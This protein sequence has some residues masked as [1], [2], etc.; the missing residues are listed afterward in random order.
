MSKTSN[1]H[2]FSQS[3]FASVHS[4]SLISR[5]LLPWLATYPTLQMI[6]IHHQAL[7]LLDESGQ[8]ITITSQPS[9]MGPFHLLVPEFDFTQVKIDQ[10]ADWYN[11]Q[12]RI[13]TQMIDVF[14]ANR[15][16]ALVQWSEISHDHLSVSMII[17]H[18]RRGFLQNDSSSHA[19]VQKLLVSAC[20]SLN[21]AITGLSVSELK[22]AVHQLAGLGPG[23]TPAGDDVLLGVMAGLWMKIASLSNVEQF[24]RQ[25]IA[26]IAA[27]AAPRTTHLSAMWLLAAAHGEFGAPWHDLADALAADNSAQLEATI[28]QIASIGASSGLDALLGLETTLNAVR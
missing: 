1:H 10:T 3:T 13:G 5:S 22:T 9:Y 16:D 6:G 23:L 25:A 14:H 20:D 8:I 27:E 19:V 28:Q 17:Q 26:L 12:L 15:W 11:G 18:Q 21:N 24:Y 2:K 7:N 4:A